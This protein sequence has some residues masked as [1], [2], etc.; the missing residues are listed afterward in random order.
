MIFVY[1][2]EFLAFFRAVVSCIEEPVFIPGSTGK[3]S[4]FD[5]VGEKFA[6]CDVHHIN[7]HP[8]GTAALYCISQIFTVVR[9]T[10]S[11][12]GD[13]AVVR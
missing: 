9:L 7:L 2:A 5:M 12:Q 4:P 13:S 3:L 11:A 8:V 6:C 1:V 10:C